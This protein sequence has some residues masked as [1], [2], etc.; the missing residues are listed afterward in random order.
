MLGAPISDEEWQ[1]SCW[2]IINSYFDEKGLVRQ[3]LD[4]FNEFITL[5]MKQ[6]IMDTQALEL[7]PVRQYTGSD[8]KELVP[9]SSLAL[10]LPPNHPY[11]CY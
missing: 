11:R 3:Q 5:T 8:D 1:E 6:I 9:P 7:E 4:S 2:Q 10:S